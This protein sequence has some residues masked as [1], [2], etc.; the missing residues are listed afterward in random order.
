MG[1]YSLPAVIKHWYT[2]Q[3]L[4]R[5]FQ[6]GARYHTAQLM[7]CVCECVCLCHLLLFLTT[8]A[9]QVWDFV[10][11][12]VFAAWHRLLG[13]WCLYHCL[14][15]ISLNILGGHRV[16]TFT[17]SC[18]VQRP[19]T[20]DFFFFLHKGQWLLIETGGEFHPY[21][22]IVHITTYIQF[23]TFLVL[24]NCNCNT[25]RCFF[26]PCLNRCLFAIVIFP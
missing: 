21:W 23:P 11:C 22:K 19:S 14:K 1:Y 25:S 20:A 16:F 7:L 18:G 6:V 8:A 5:Q 12:E 26:W 17:H 13:I 24:H 2:L 9:V 4:W 10:L 3:W 15:A